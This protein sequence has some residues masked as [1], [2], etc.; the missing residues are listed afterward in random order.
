MPI[1]KKESLNILIVAAEDSSAA[2]ARRL[3]QIWQQMGV[4]CKAAGIGSREMESLGF[5]ILGRSEDLAV[6]GLQEIVAHWSVIKKAFYD[7]L[8]YA[9]QEKPDFILLMDYPEFNLRLAK[10]IKKMGVPVIYYIS[11]QIW[12]WR[13]YRV[14]QI[15]KIVDLMLVI[16]PFEEKFYKEHNVPARYV[17]HPLL[18]LLDEKKHSLESVTQIREKLLS[19]SKKRI[20]GIMPGSRR[21]ELK[22]NLQTQIEAAREVERLHGDVQTVLFIA[23]SL[24]ETFVIEQCKKFNYTGLFLK[25]DPFLMIQ[26]AD[27]VLCASGTATLMVGLCEKPMVI[28]Y[29]MNVFSGMMAKFLVNKIPFFGMVNLILERE[30]VPERFQG[31]ANA[32]ELAKCLSRFITDLTYRDGVVN[33]LRALRKK[34]GDGGGLQMLAKTLLEFEQK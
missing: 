3:L 16:F 15:K 20:L 17:G 31:K 8:K 32:K 7:V 19:S 10:K 18:Q 33:D 12:A 26:A 1:S 21:S 13:S 34:L 28:M 27:E 4:T 22:H 9:K 30:V 5:R 11:P 23:P 24:N 6:V 25:E 2:Y 14:H 29:K